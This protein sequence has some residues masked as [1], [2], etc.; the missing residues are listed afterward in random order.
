MP[1]CAYDFL[2]LLQSSF[3]NP[4]R[5]ACVCTTTTT[6]KH[7]T[8]YCRTHLS[9]GFSQSSIDA[10][11]T[12][13]IL[14]LGQQLEALLGSKKEREEEADGRTGGTFS[15]C[16]EPTQQHQRQWFISLMP[17]GAGVNQELMRSLS[18]VVPAARSLPVPAMACHF[19]ETAFLG[20][21][22][23]SSP[24]CGRQMGKT[25]ERFL[26]YECTWSR[27]DG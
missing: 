20:Q 4:P 24:L 6:R 13:K 12:D 21:I 22:P 16:Y 19:D 26:I 23:S 10:N 3:S 17:S 11:S 25:R 8:F 18:V 15:V 1:I 14:V 2:P 27:E 7:I 5:A 9:S